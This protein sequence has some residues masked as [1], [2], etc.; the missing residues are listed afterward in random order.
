MAENNCIKQEQV[1]D[2]PV[3]VAV[4]PNGY[5][6]A[7]QGNRFVMPE[8]RRMSMGTFLDKLQSPTK[9][10]ANGVFYIQKQNSNLKDEFSS[11]MK[12]VK[13]FDWAQKAFG[14]SPDAVNFW[15]GDER[16]ITSMHKDPY[17]NLYC[18]VSGQK[19]F[20]L[21]PPSDIA[22][23]PYEKFPAATYKENLEG[24]FDII[25][26]VESPE[27]PWI[28]IDPLNPDLVKY[29]SYGKTQPLK[30]SVKAGQVLYLPSLWFHHV[31]QSH[32]CIAVNFWYDM[33]FDFKWAYYRFLGE[34]VGHNS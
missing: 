6:D 26:E 18:V 4:T 28:N 33:V 10:Q 8:E 9:D 34:L 30:F 14:K 17:E 25:D 27:V 29:P 16:A 1:G 32:G 13:P 2:V 20:I 31:Q 11:L 21:L 12:D 23:L 3:T 7:I 24:E 15:M 22:Y 19:D 5:A